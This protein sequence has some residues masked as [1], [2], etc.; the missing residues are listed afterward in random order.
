VL[1]EL[2]AGQT[3]VGVLQHAVQ[4]FQTLT[5]RVRSEVAEGLV[6]GAIGGQLDHQV[7]L[8]LFVAG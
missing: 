1:E 3:L 5:E 2:P 4:Y 6:V 8:R 7:A